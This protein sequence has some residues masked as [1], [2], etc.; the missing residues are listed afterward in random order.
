VTGKP[1]TGYLQIVRRSEITE[2]DWSVEEAIRTVMSAGI[3]K[4]DFVTIVSN[5]DI[6]ANVYMKEGDTAP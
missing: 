3:L 4:P 1:T 2:L 6:A 5:Q